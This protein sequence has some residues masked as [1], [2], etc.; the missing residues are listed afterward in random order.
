MS[1]QEKTMKTR[2]KLA[3]GFMGLIAPKLKT[4]LLE[5]KALMRDLPRPFT[6]ML[7]A[8]YGN[9]SLVGCEVGYGIGENAENLLS[10]LNIKKLYSVDPFFMTSAYQ[11]CGRSVD[12][13]SKPDQRS[14][15]RM[16]TLK[17]TGKIEF[18]TATSD[19]A[20]GSGVVPNGLDFVYIDGNHEFDYCYRDIV[21]GMH[22]VKRGGFVGAM[23]SRMI[24]TRL[25]MPFLILARNR[26]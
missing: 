5:A 15:D 7:K 2:H 10:E 19:K 23:T 1:I 22:L 25:R 3:F 9:R 11:E 16:K 4:D 21:N 26:V 20:F 6:K 24:V 17:D 8:E 14:H 18:V 12:W 13:F